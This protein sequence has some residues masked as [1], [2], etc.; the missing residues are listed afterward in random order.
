MAIFMEMMLAPYSRFEQT[1]GDTEGQGKR[2]LQFMMSQRVGHDT[3]TEQQR[4]E[5]KA[6]IDQS[7]LDNFLQRNKKL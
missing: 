7:I 4:D 5:K 2:M 6:S 3:V 1:P